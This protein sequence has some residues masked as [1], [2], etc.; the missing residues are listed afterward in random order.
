MESGD[1]VIVN[2]VLLES[3]SLA[4]VWIFC[5]LS[6]SPM[7]WLARASIG[8]HMAIFKGG[9]GE[10]CMSGVVAAVLVPEDGQCGFLD[11][12]C[13]VKLLAISPSR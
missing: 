11:V 6:L 3:Y 9:A 5:P 2:T 7:L 8:S 13:H 10:L 4:V 1:A 12:T